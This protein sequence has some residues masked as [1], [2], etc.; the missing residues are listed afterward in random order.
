MDIS[1][2]A[3]LDEPDAAAFGVDGNAANTPWVGAVEPA[4]I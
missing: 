2:K 1:T 4:A 3:Q